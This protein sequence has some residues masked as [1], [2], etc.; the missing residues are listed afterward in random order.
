MQEN[1]EK[2]KAL[3]LEV[4]DLTSALSILQWDQSTYMPPQGGASRGR[5]IATIGKL[6][7]EKGTAPELGH[8]LDKL[9]PWAETF[10]Y[11]SDEASLVRVARRDFDENTKIPAAFMGAFNNHQAETYEIWI[12]AR[13]ENNFKAVQAPLEKTLDFSRKMAQYFSNYEH[14]ADPLIQMAEP[15]SKVSRILPVFEELK[16]GLVPLLKEIKARGL[17]KVD[18]PAGKY[19]EAKQLEFSR[20]VVKLFGFDFTR[21]R[22]DKTH[23]PFMTKFAWGD[24]RMTTRVYEDQVDNSLF[25]TMHEAGHALYELGCRPELDGTPL[26]TGASV[27]VH[28]SQSRLWENQVGRSLGFWQHFYPELQA[29]FPEQLKKFP[30]EKFYR[31]INWVEPSLIRVDADELTYNLHIVIR[32][33]LELE[34][35]EGKVSIAELPQVWRERYEKNLGV[36]SPD[37]RNGVMQDVH[38]YGGAIG[39]YFQGYSIGNILSAQFFE[40]AVKAHPEI[41]AQIG[42]G[43]F[44]TLRAWLQQNLHQHGRKF[45]A[46]ELVPKITGEAM[47]LKPYI[48]YLKKKYLAPELT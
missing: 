22:L 40:A 47:T 24:V 1:Y 20:N 33:E 11:D 36:S 21:G 2:L 28:E 23:H 35:L 25:S 3:L 46:D 15:G 6:R 5:Q 39:G 43:E 8:L 17:E 4:D 30:L 48:N 19:E 27:G 42:Q 26:G 12:K 31:A 37:D 34:L 32:F 13:P 29:R 14:I 9:A 18:F 38:W 16:E 41:P 7:H 10:G 44:S 45:T